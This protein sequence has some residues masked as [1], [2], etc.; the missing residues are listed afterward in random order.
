M[1]L[2]KRKTQH[3]IWFFFF[4]QD[5]HPKRKGRSREWRRRRQE[6]KYVFSEI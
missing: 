3:F 5:T 6:N 1:I 2:P 4:W